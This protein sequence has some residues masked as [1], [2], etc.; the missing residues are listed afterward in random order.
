ML[1]K[2][3][4]TFLILLILLMSISSISYGNAAEPPS[5]M[6]IVANA[7]EDLQISIGEGETY[8]EAKVV[9][10]V[11]ESYYV[12]YL[13]ETKDMS[14]HTINVKT[15]NLSYQVDFQKPVYTYQN[16]Y[17]LNLQSQSLTP[18]KSTSRSILLVSMRIIITLIIE[19]IVFYLFGFRNR[20]SWRVFL[21]INL[22]TQGTLNIWING[23]FPIQGYIFIGLT[24]IEVLILLVEGVV[25]SSAVK[26]HKKSRKWLFV[27]SAN[28]LSLL[29]GGYILTVLPF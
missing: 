23:L 3:S 28:L 2:D 21:V 1:K 25:I 7:P 27:I 18:G 17:S 22:I 10:K 14:S 24:F 19:G 26:E 20:H 6:I 9:D 4:S 13:R 8:A 15:D 11:L 29:V 12:F 5:I 16:I